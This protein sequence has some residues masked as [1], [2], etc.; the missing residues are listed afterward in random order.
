M[1]S[2]PITTNIKILM[3]IPYLLYLW[4]LYSTSK[5]KA[6][7][8]SDIEAWAQYRDYIDV[9]HLNYSLLR[10]L[11]LQPEFVSQFKMRLGFMGHFVSGGVNCELPHTE[12]IG[13]GFVFMHGI[14]T[15]FNCA[16]QLGNHCMVLHNVTIGAGHGGTPTL[17]NYVY[18]GAGA[19][20]I[21][22]VHIGDHVKIGAGAIV[23]DDVPS[24]STVVCDKA[25]VL[26]RSRT[27]YS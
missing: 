11:A 16:A 15:V 7:I 22:G 26:V 8:N 24:N 13:R 9:H 14:G 6:I 21:G 1:K 17:G 4:L 23:V 12:S 18:V 5:N 20:I 2:L 19:I 27:N 25:R 3:K 10:L